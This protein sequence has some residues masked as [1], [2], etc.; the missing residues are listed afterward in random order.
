LDD[1]LTLDRV[2]EAAAIHLELCQ[3]LA[4]ANNRENSSLA[5]KYLHFHRPAFFPIVDSI[6]REG[7]SW[8]MDDLEGSYRVGATSA[9]SL[10]IGL[11][12]A[13]SGTPRFDGGQPSARRQSPANR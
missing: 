2:P 6:V 9:K 13:C 4:T 10:A 3:A 1:K 11:V 12:C 5:S 8:V 7:W